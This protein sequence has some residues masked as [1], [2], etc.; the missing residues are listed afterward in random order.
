VPRNFMRWIYAAVIIA[1]C[2]IVWFAWHSA[3][4]VHVE[5]I[6]LTGTVVA[7][8]PES[9]TVTVKNDNMPGFMEPMNMDYKVKDKPSFS[10][11]KPGEKIHATL[12]TDRQNL[13]D[14]ENVNI[15][16]TK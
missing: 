6:P 9:Q 8:H 16:A 3:T 14:L 5:R 12:A 4:T 7:V 13:F 11:L 1:V 2:A 15:D 10:Q